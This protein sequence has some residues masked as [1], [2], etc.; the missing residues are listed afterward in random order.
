MVTVCIDHT[1]MH[2][3][4]TLD[5]SNVCGRQAAEPYSLQN[6]ALVR[7]RTQRPP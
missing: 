2:Q 6:D 5:A 1:Y 7:F 3:V 4:R